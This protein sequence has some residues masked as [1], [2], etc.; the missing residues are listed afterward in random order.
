MI[1]A[2]VM[3]ND[4]SIGIAAQSGNFQLNVMLP[5]IAHSLIESLELLASGAKL[6]GEKAIAGFTVNQAHI[7]SALSRNPVLVTALNPVI[8]YDLGAKIAK[9]A[10]RENRPVL[11]VAL[12]QTDL[13]EAELRRYLDPAA[14]TLGGDPKAGRK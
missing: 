10:Y 13:S 3:G 6:L 11:E 1:A 5:L 14:M 8:G 4:A 9:Q 12:E 7:D 2:K